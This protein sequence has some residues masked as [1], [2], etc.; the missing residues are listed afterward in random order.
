MLVLLIHIT[1]L[2]FVRIARVFIGNKR[3]NI[4][5]MKDKNIVLEWTPIEGSSAVAL[6]N[7]VFT[8]RKEVRR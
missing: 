7:F 6:E 8:D 1:P 4:H 2:W 3:Q 5:H